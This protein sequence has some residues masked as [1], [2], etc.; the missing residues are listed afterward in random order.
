MGDDV[1]LVQRGGMQHPG[2]AGK[3]FPDKGRVSDVAGDPGVRA[4]LA[5]EAYYPVPTGAKHPDERLAEMARAAR[6]ENG[7]VAHACLLCRTMAPLAIVT[8]SKRLATVRL[9]LILVP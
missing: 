2:D 1:R 8:L 3:H 5:V 9:Q 4:G 6:D 7:P